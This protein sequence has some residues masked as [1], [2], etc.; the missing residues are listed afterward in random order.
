MFETAVRSSR[1]NEAPERGVTD[2]SSRREED[3]TSN[4]PLTDATGLIVLTVATVAV[5]ALV[6]PLAQTMRTLAA[7]SVSWARP[8]RVHALIVQ[9]RAEHVP[10]AGTHP[11][12]LP[13]TTSDSSMYGAAQSQPSRLPE[14]RSE[15]EAFIA[16]VLAP[17]RKTQ[18]GACG[19][20]L[21]RATT[22]ATEGATQLS[23][24]SWPHPPGTSARMT[25]TLVPRRHTK[26][27]SKQ[28]AFTG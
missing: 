11:N 9:F 14:R 23:R 16:S 28:H 1:T 20:E 22:E 24:R 10:V 7:Y 21:G 4:E 19:G 18:S 25:V 13:L 27:S 15:S 26:N 2:T 8:V 5:Q 17:P 3:D 12:R 6:T